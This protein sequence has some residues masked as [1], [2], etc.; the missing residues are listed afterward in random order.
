MNK[1]LGQLLGLRDKCA[2]YQDEIN[3]KSERGNGIK[4]GCF[5]M[6]HNYAV[7]TLELL[8]FYK[9][10]WENPK[11]L[12]LE[13]PRMDEDLERAR[14]ENAERII[15]ATKCLFIKSLSAI[16]YSAKEAI[17][18]K[19]H[20]L[21]SWYQEQKSK[22]RRIYLSGIISESYRMGLVN[23]KQ[24]E[25]WDC[26]I[27]MRN[28]IVHNNG[29]ADKNVKYRINDLEIVF[30]ENKM[31]KGKLDTFVKLTDIAVDLYYSWVLVSE[32]YKTGE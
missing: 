11:V 6:I 4:A 18:D 7:A 2:K 14:K 27:Y 21:H 19:E 9:I 1:L 16:E 29:V 28:M 26:L 23:K 5:G 25:Y 20:P 3:N 30:G 32:K 13:V 10:V 17:K 8:N 31:T 22:N 15:D 24:K 12:G